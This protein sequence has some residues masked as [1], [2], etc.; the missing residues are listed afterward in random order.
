MVGGGKQSIL[1]GHWDILL[2]IAT[3]HCH[4]ISW[5]QTIQVGVEWCGVVWC[6]VVAP[7]ARE[8]DRPVLCGSCTAADAVPTG[9]ICLIPPPLSNCL[10]MGS[11]HAILFIVLVRACSREQLLQFLLHV[12]PPLAEPLGGHTHWCGRLGW[13]WRGARLLRMETWG[14][15]TTAPFTPNS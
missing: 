1:H 5:Y 3:Q 4:C 7:V 13:T 9:G 12:F 10:A 11:C 8:C 14:D 2:A 6:G 15:P